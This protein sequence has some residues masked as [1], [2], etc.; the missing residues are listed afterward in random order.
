M[1][2]AECRPQRA[3]VSHKML[4]CEDEPI[5]GAHPGRALVSKT[6]TL[7]DNILVRVLSR[8]CIE[9]VMLRFTRQHSEAVIIAL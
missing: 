7:E 5:W 4:L 8:N 9:C 6:L 3:C 2:A 1:Q